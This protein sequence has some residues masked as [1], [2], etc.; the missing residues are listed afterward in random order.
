ME[1]QEYITTA[2]TMAVDGALL[3]THEKFLARITISS[4]RLLMKIGADLG[5]PIEALTAQ[6]IIAW[7]EADSKRQLASEGAVLQWGD[8]Q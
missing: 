5:K 6:E 8:E 2:E 7:F 1:S 3:S 4:L